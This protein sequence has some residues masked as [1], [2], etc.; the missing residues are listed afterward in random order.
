VARPKDELLRLA[1]TPSGVRFDPDHR[2]PGRGAYL[3]PAVACVT[4]ARRRDAAAIRR[5]LR[6]AAVDEVL[7]ALDALPTEVLRHQVPERTVRSENA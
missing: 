6:G 4:A 5:A 7:A 2:L 1:R 3:C